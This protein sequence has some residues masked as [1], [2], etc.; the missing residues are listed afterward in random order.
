MK[1]IL[2]LVIMLLTIT[3]VFAENQLVF[4][5]QWN[6]LYYAENR[7]VNVSLEDSNIQLQT[8]TSLV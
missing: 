4:F 3:S 2:L 1:K 6:L 7:S 5:N 8:P